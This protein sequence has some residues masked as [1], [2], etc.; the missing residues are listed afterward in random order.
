MQFV[1]LERASTAEFV[2]YVMLTTGRRLNNVR[3]LITMLSAGVLE[4]I[5]KLSRH[6]HSLIV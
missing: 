3:T 5:V 4:P 2:I 1:D 6:W